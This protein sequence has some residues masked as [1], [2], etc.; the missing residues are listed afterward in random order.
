MTGGGRRTEISAGGP[1]TSP[2]LRSA[3]APRGRFRA[4]GPTTLTTL[5]LAPPTAQAKKDVSTV[6]ELLRALTG[7]AESPT[8]PRK[9]DAGDSATRLSSSPAP[10]VQVHLNC[11]IVAVRRHFG[12]CARVNSPLGSYVLALDG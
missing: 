7:I 9:T 4:S 10:D 6:T 8:Q 2:W 11:L 1:S 3:M 5:E 12:G